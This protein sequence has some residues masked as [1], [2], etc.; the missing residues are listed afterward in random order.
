MPTCRSGR[1][2]LASGACA[3]AV[4]RREPTSASTLPTPGVVQLDADLRRAA[5]L[6]QMLVHLDLQWREAQL[7]QLSRLIT[8]S[9]AGWRGDLTGE[10]HLDGTTESAQVKTRLSATGV[11]RAEFAPNEA[12]D[13]D[14]NCGL[15]FH[16]SSNGIENLNC[17]SP[18]GE[19]RIRMLG[20]L[21]GNSPP[22]LSV[23]LQ[24]IPVQAG[25][26]VLRTLRS[27][28]DEDLEAKGTVS[29]KIA[30]DPAA[31]LK[32]AP[33]APRSH[34]RKPAAPSDSAEPAKLFGTLTVD[35]FSLSGSNLNQPFSIPKMTFAPAVALVGRPPA[36][37][38]AVALPAGAPEPLALTVQFALS[39]YQF[40]VHGPASLPRIRDL[41]HVAGRSNPAALDSLA[42]GPAILDLSA[43]GP[44]LPAINAPLLQ[45][46]PDGQQP[47]GAASPAGVINSASDR[48]SGT[49]TLHNA[50]WKTGSLSGHIEISD[51][52]LQI[53]GEG[54]VWDP[55]VFT[56]G[57][58]KGTASLQ[59]ASGL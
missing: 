4:S 40:T 9:D 25:L 38:A 41:A 35:G 45:S 47:G 13:F 46:T 12:L 50:N 48:L 28:L 51:A 53:G 26:D 10:L 3:S 24:R 39:G 16:Y 23:E 6:R 5:G 44:W 20:T 18:L 17:D 8:G 30:Y 36:L 33:K 32:P 43:Q 15:T 42:G 7:G 1:R 19:G 14:A 21:P 22:R 34:R 29:G 57:P 56:Y 31:E 2:I 58:V 49:V 11:H 27:G 55:V 52:T 54:V 59:A 37:T